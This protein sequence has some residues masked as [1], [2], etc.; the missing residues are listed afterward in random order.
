[1]T[2]LNCLVE[3]IN[4]DN[5]S[6]HSLKEKKKEKERLRSVGVGYGSVVRMSPQYDYRSFTFISQ[7]N[8]VYIAKQLQHLIG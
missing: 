1:M 3:D 8:K 5:S 6:L 2:T 7:Q 4:L